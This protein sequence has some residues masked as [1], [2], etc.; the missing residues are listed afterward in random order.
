[1]LSLNDTNYWFHQTLTFGQQIED[2]KEA[3]KCLHSFLDSF[4]KE[5]EKHCQMGVLYIMGRQQS[6]RVHFHLILFCYPPQALTVEK[7]AERLRDAAW[8]RWQKHGRGPKR[9]FNKL[10]IRPKARALDYLLKGHFAIAETTRERGKPR[11]YD[12]WNIGEKDF[13]KNHSSPVQRLEVRQ[14]FTELFEGDPFIRNF[15]KPLKNQN[16]FDTPTL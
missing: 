1:M 6:R 11:W 13:I 14:E 16:P 12:S 5:M 4:A 7:L 8:E 9:R 3:K 2:F 15:R 10:T